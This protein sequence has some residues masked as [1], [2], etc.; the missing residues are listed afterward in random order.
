MI[1]SDRSIREEIAEGRIEI[2]RLA[3]STPGGADYQGQRGTTAGRFF[4]EFAPEA[5]TRR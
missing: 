3:T 1:L 2:E 4:E 5:R